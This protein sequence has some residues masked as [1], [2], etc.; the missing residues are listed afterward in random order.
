MIGNTV[1]TSMK[2]KLTNK[3]ENEIKGMCYMSNSNEGIVLAKV[4]Y[5]E[6]YMEN[7]KGL[8]CQKNGRGL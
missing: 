1:K 6:G 2:Q 8:P 5:A 4:F 3:D 7:R